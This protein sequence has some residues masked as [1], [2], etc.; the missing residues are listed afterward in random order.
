LFINGHIYQE[1][2]YS[3]HIYAIVLL[4]EL[5]QYNSIKLMPLPTL[6]AEDQEFLQE[7][8]DSREEVTANLANNI[9]NII[10]SNQ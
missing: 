10:I 1:T 7:I 9:K 6:S 3:T 2:S 4:E 5:F 8:I